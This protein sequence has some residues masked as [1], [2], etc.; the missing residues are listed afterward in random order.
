MVLQRRVSVKHEAI[1][2]QMQSI[3]VTITCH[4]L[5]YDYE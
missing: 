1:T 4:L 2:V 5:D 3:V